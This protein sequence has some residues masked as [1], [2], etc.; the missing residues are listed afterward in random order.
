MSTDFDKTAREFTV[1]QWIYQAWMI[2]DDKEHIKIKSLDSFWNTTI[3]R[4]KHVHDNR[5][6]MVLHTIATAGTQMSTCVKY[7]ENGE[8][9]KSLLDLM[10]T[11]IA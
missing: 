9:S 2:N 1:V 10:V 5:F 3:K 8:S 6:G 4:T 11:K 7:K